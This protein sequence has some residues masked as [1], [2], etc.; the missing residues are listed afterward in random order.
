MEHSLFSQSLQAQTDF[1][2]I[3]EFQNTPLAKGTHQKNLR[4]CDRRKNK[5]LFIYK[6][7]IH[8]FC[9]YILET[10]HLFLDKLFCYFSHTVFSEAAN[11]DKKDLHCVAELL[12]C[13]KSVKIFI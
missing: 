7:Y 11:K 4:D 2:L 8:D 5:N 3:P 10:Y 12:S 6:V 9:C 13:L 1:L